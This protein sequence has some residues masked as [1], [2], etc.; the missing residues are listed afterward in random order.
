MFDTRQTAREPKLQ[1]LRSH[2]R[3]RSGDQGKMCHGMIHSGKEESRVG[4]R[5]QLD[6]VRQW[7]RRRLQTCSY[8][9]RVAVQW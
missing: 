3:F 1:D 9:C 6:S 2:E 8:M 7:L 5:R 4:G